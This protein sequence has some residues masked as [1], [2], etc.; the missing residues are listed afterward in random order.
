MTTEA[1]DEEAFDKLNEFEIENKIF[2]AVH[3]EPGLSVFDGV[4]QLIQ[5]TKGGLHAEIHE[6]DGVRV[7]FFT[8]ARL[9]RA[10]VNKWFK[11]YSEWI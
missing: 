5:N 11:L 1:T 2:S 7:V 4:L 8:E 9:Y 6:R 3:L 10:L